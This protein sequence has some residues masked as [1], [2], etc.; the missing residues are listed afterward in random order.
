MLCK[1]LDE[2]HH[3]C[4]SEESLDCLCKRII[5]VSVIEKYKQLSES[6]THPV[7]FQHVKHAMTITPT[8]LML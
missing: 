5:T 6:G 4:P 3:G 2:V 7:C 8:C 1:I